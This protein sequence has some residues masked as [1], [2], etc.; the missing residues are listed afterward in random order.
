M[1]LRELGADQLRESPV[2]AAAGRI[3]EGIADGVG[4]AGAVAVERD[5]RVHLPA[6]VLHVVRNAAGNQPRLEAG[7]LRELRDQGAADLGHD[8]DLACGA[9]LLLASGLPRVLVAGLHENPAARHG[10]SPPR[11]GASF[12]VSTARLVSQESAAAFARASRA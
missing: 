2:D 7:I 12:D 6:T 9:G 8:L 10:G 5:E 11:F 1:E 4:A 3:A